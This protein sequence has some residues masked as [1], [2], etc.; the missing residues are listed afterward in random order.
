MFKVKP[1]SC[2]TIS[3]VF[4]NFCDNE[5][6]QKINRPG[7]QSKG[8]DVLQKKSTMEVDLKSIFPVFCKHMLNVIKL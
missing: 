2:K 3:H 7:R 1:I 5:E 4:S 8:I 6:P